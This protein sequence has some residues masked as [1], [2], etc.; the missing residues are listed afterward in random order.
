MSY[1]SQLNAKSQEL[2]EL[3]A[4][5]LSLAPAQV[6][7]V[8]PSPRPYRYR[9]RIDLSVRRLRNGKILAGFTDK[10]GRGICEITSCAIARPEISDALPDVVARLPDTL[11]P[12]YRTANLILRY[13]DDGRVVTGGIGRRSLKT[14]PEDYLYASIDDIRV[15][16]GMDTFFQGNTFILPSLRRVLKSMLQPLDRPRLLDLY[17]G[18]G[19]F[20]L[21][22]RPWIS[23]ALLIEENPSS[24]RAAQFNKEFH[25]FDNLEIV[26][27]KL[28]TH[29][30]AVGDS[31]TANRVALV[32]PPRKGLGAFTAEFLAQNLRSLWYLSC[33]PESQAADLKIFLHHGWRIGRITPFDFFPQTRHL[34]V[35]TELARD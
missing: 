28:E 1:E 3:F 31:A 7:S 29:L 20:S 35:L 21:L 22:L 18:V 4:D 19:L 5:Q 32:D 10:K 14:P 13:S 17:G 6:E 11:P 34:E 9:N 27:G 8:V 33:N 23:G 15:Y 2:R 30:P 26:S 24:I 16:Y 12:K 25:Q